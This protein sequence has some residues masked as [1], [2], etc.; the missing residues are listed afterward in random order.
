MFFGFRLCSLCLS[1]LSLCAAPSTYLS[2]KNLRA[3]YWPLTKLWTSISRFVYAFDLCDCPSQFHFPCLI[4][5][6]FVGV[7]RFEFDRGFY[8]GN[9]YLRSLGSDCCGFL[10]NWVRLDGFVFCFCF[11]FFFRVL[12]VNFIERLI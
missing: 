6:I 11:F 5:K 9:I 4:F 8:L 3:S 10:C 1:L 7:T 2:L 12:G